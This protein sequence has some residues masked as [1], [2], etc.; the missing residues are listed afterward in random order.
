MR[1]KHHFPEKMPTLGVFGE[2]LL[3]VVDTVLYSAGWLALP[4][5]SCLE[6]GLNKLTKSAPR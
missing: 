5:K 1:N 3:Q 4:L 6:W 2:A